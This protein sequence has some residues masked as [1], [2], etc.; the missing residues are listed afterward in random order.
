MSKSKSLAKT[1]KLILYRNPWLRKP[2]KILHDTHIRAYQLSKI[3]RDYREHLKLLEIAKYALITGPP[4]VGKTTLLKLFLRSLV[5]RNVCNVLLLYGKD[6]KLLNL[7]MLEKFLKQMGGLKSI[8]LLID[9]LVEEEANF[10][11]ELIDK[12]NPEFVII[13]SRFSSIIHCFPGFFKLE[14]LPMDVKETFEAVTKRSANED[15][16]E[17]IRIFKEKDGGEQSFSFNCNY[18]MKSFLRDLASFF[19]FYLTTGGIPR[20]LEERLRTGAVRYNTYISLY[21]E[22]RREMNQNCEGILSHIL[23][24]TLDLIAVPHSIRARASKAKISFNEFYACIHRL[25][26]MH[27]LGVLTGEDFKIYFRDP[28]FLYSTLAILSK[29][30]KEFK[31][32]IIKWT[33]G[34]NVGYIVEN[35]VFEHL[36]RGFGS[37]LKY[38]K[39]S[40]GE[41]DFL[42]DLLE[43]K[44]CGLEVKYRARRREKDIRK[45]IE[46]SEREYIKPVLI[47]REGLRVYKFITVVPVSVFLYII[48][49]LWNRKNFCGDHYE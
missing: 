13:T 33:R 46:I 1:R 39:T 42:I 12:I 27:V 48:S 34:D 8:S 44:S 16:R 41:I 43:G 7:E 22:I 15:L 5:E 3:K 24:S 32:K 23:S 49:F 18:R 45:L 14:L 38:I 2:K 10:L 36:Y 21:E 29:D 19:V 35:I 40:T 17:L 6:F 26:D 30:E 28:A 9:N 20:I 47:T 25:I 31:K 37:A 11:W 4:W